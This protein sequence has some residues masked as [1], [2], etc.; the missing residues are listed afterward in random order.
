MGDSGRRSLN[1]EREILKGPWREKFEC[2][3]LESSFVITRKR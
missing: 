1:L 2:S 3:F